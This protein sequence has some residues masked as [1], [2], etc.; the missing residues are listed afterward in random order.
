MVD[1]V[2]KFSQSYSFPSPYI[3]YLHTNGAQTHPIILIINAI[4]AEKSV[5]FLGT[6]M[7]ATNCSRMALAA[8]AAASGCGQV[9]RGVSAH[10]HPYANLMSLDILEH[11]STWVVGTTNPR[12]HMLSQHWDVMCDLDTG[13]VIISDRY[14]ES[15]IP[16]LAHVTAPTT[17]PPSAKAECAD[18]IFM[19]D[20]SSRSRMEQ[21]THV[22]L[23]RRLRVIMVRLTCGNVS[24]ITL[25]V[26][27]VSQR[28]MSTRSLA[29]HRSATP[30]RPTPRGDSVAEQCSRMKRTRRGKWLAIPL[31]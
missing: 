4:L 25:H 7:P 31:G 30:L 12:F 26:T 1:F 24:S 16:G 18:N 22:R 14:Q 3:P 29:R 11:R 23:W 19:E 9:L 21:D 13:R 15:Q 5:I 6:N 28:I 20:V 8:C 17:N 27:S 10:S 2:N